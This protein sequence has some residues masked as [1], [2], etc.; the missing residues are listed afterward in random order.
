MR[1]RK[2]TASPSYM[3]LVILNSVCPHG[4][5]CLKKEARDVNDSPFGQMGIAHSK[6]IEYF[7]MV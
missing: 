6:G 1:T 2:K 4:Q 7:L 3:L 5:S